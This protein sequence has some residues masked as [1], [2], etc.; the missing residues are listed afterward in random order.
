MVVLSARKSFNTSFLS[1]QPTT[2]CKQ[3]PVFVDSPYSTC[4][5]SNSSTLIQSSVRVNWMYVFHFSVTSPEDTRKQC[6]EIFLTK[7]DWDIFSG[8]ERKLR[9]SIFRGHVWSNILNMLSTSPA[10]S[11]QSTWFV[12]TNS[13]R[14]SKL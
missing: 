6:T 1:N 4:F 11:D 2:I 7:K 14:T 5:Y 12:H 10:F 13:W 9:P 3:I 8:A